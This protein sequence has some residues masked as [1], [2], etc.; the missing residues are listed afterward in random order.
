MAAIL[1]M[2][3]HIQ[4]CEHL[5]CEGKWLRELSTKLLLP[6]SLDGLSKSKSQFIELVVLNLLYICDQINIGFLC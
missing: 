5:K 6:A 3:I 2:D 1:V 4:Q